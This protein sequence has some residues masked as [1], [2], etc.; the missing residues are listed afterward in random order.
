MPFALV[1]IGLI[2]VI[3]GAKDTHEELG[4]QLTEDFTGP[5]NFIK[6]AAAIAGLGAVGYVKDLQPIS[7]LAL[8][9]LFV[10]MILSNG[11]MFD[12][13]MQA[14]NQGPEA[15]PRPNQGGSAA[16]GDTGALPANVNDPLAWLRWIENKTKIPTMQGLPGADWIG[17]QSAQ[18]RENFNVFM[19]SIV[20]LFG[21]LIGI[22]GR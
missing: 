20:P 3:T 10:V 14:V 17:A 4:K 15:I 12:K 7:R 18:V 6:W 11:G 8:A 22:P 13:F 5:D 1:L 21:K 2:M 16:P 9:L 19:G